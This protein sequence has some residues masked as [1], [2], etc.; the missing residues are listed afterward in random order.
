MNEKVLA[1]LVGILLIRVLVFAGTRI[2]EINFFGVVIK[3][4][5]DIQP[6]TQNSLAATSVSSRFALES[7]PQPT[8]TRLPTYTPYPAQPTYTPYPT[9][10]PNVVVVTPRPVKV[11]ATLLPQAGV[12]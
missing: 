2:G 4:Q 7:L 6:T 12:Q 3:F 9:A 10:A 1:A 8:Y 11:T 5:Q